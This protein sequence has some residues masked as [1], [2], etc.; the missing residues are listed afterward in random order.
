MN[1]LITNNF[2][3]FLDK[4]FYY[5]IFP[6]LVIAIVGLIFK[7]YRHFP[8]KKINA[9][10]G[11]KIKENGLIHFTTLA[12][13]QEIQKSGLK[14]QNKELFFLEKNMVWLYMYEA[15]N[16]DFYKNIVQNKGHRDIY[17]CYIHFEGITDEQIS[18]MRYRKYDSAITYIGTF[19]T[20]RM[21]IISVSKKRTE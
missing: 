9:N 13:A 8:N 16:I 18:N 17:D 4:L 20:P 12:N 6:V 1:L 21:Q 10:I 14:P 19:R 2:F 11:K 7:I 15:Q 3:S 5:F